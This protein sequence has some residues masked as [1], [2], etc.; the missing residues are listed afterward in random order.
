[1]VPILEAYV[2]YITYSV[3][4]ITYSS[5][6]HA[7]QWFCQQ[8][9]HKYRENY[10]NNIKEYWSIIPYTKKEKA[11]GFDENTKMEY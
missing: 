6:M 5:T 2:E 10:Q 11:E 7:S 8:E 4:Y 1:M 3:E 9:K